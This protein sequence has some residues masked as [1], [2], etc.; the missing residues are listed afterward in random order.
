M[1]KL[2]KRH[3]FDGIHTHTNTQKRV[4][5]VRRMFSSSYDH[6]DDDDLV[7]NDGS[8]TLPL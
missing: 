8:G 2:R 3:W 6:N 7:E 1:V 5:F 4:A